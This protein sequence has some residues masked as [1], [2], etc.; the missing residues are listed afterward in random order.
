MDN[1][2]DHDLFYDKS[3]E[4]N[5]D[6]DSQN[7]LEGQQESGNDNLLR[8]AGHPNL[9]TEHAQTN[10]NRTEATQNDNHF[11]SYSMYNMSMARLRFVVLY[12]NNH[13]LPLK[14]LGQTK[15][16]AN[17]TSGGRRY[18]KL[19]F[20]EKGELFSYLYMFLDHEVV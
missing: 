15:E 7:E 19:G 2:S 9:P 14:R 1:L 3:I 6:L 18:S 17:G 5:E 8:P 12:R 11:A 20:K 13:T 16:R 4:V 10:N